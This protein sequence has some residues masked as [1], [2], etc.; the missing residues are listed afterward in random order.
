M[1]F[2][3]QSNFT[4]GKIKRIIEQEPSPQFYN[5]SFGKYDAA[6]EEGLNTT[7]QRQ[8]QFAQMLHLREVGVPIPD[9][10]LVESATLQNKKELT[11]AIKSAQ[12]QRSQ[13]E[14]MRAQVEVQ[15]LQSRIELAQARAKADTGLGLERVSR[16]EENRALSVERRANAVN[17]EQQAFLNMVKALKEIDDIDITQIQKIVQLQQIIK[18][19]EQQVKQQEQPIKASNVPS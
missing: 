4:P 17:E 6:I 11:D 13:M 5:K 14:Q 3:S 12:E 10:V 7:T 2:R 15:E 19:Q 1:L 8:M 16:I 9:D 18:S